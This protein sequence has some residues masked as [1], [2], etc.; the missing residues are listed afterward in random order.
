MTVIADSEDDISALTLWPAP[1]VHLACVGHD[2]IVLDLIADAYNCLLGAADVMSLSPYGTVRATDA[3]IRKE[4]LDAGIA[5]TVAP[6]NSW[7][8]PVLPARELPRTAAARDDAVFT[9]AALVLASR[10]FRGKSLVRLIAKDRP[11]TTPA[12]IQD[13]TRLDSLVAS[14]RNARPWLPGEGECLQ[15]SFELRRLL[16]ARGIEASWYFGVRTWPFSAHCWLQIGD[17]VLGDRLERV[18]FYTPIMVA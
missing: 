14:V 4:L 1:G 9:A 18:R 11:A 3:T 8:P 13:E 2:I 17:L 7:T 16:S 10:Q 12:S 6:T 15:R 5:H